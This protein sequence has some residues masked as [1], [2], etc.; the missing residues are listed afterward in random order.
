[1]TE[2]GIPGLLWIALAVVAAGAV[3]GFRLTRRRR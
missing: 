1:V 3:V 2:V